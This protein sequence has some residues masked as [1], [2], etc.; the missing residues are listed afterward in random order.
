M[1]PLLNEQIQ[2][3]VRSVFND[4]S[5]PVQVLFFGR[6]ADCEYC[7]DTQSLLE[8]VVALS[9]RLSLSVYDLDEDAV[10]AAQYRIDKAPGFTILAREGEALTD[11]GVRFYGIPSGHEF[12]T[13]INDLVMVSARN[14]GLS[15]E[16]AEYLRGIKT[17][18]NL[19]VFTTPT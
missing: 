4:L 8:E 6:K 19:Q 7:E 12:T 16:T 14:S 15:K 5:D 2:Q 18:L 9:D 1:P 13:L 11:Y 10:L 17:P 3:Q